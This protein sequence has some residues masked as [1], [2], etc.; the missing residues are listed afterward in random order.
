[1]LGSHSW[2]QG[3]LSVYTAQF[4]YQNRTLVRMGPNWKPHGWEQPETARIDATDKG[5]V[6]ASQSGYRGV[7]AASGG[8]WID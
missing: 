6:H 8:D 1:M 3:W 2:F 5:G 7:F 4:Y